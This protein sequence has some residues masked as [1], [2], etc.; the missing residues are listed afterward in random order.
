[1]AIAKKVSP[2]EMKAK[3]EKW[4]AELKARRTGTTPKDTDKADVESGKSVKVVKKIQAPAAKPKIDLTKIADY[5][6]R[7]PDGKNADK[8][9]KKWVLKGRKVIITVPIDPGMLEALDELAQELGQSRP[10]L[11]RGFIQQAIDKAHGR[12]KNK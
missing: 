2:E 12:G 4:D 11:I 10:A 5:A 7:A 6:E 8:P 9:P 1:M 3:Q